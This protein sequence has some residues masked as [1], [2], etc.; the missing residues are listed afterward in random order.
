[1]VSLHP[2]MHGE[3]TF[4]KDAE[5]SPQPQPETFGQVVIDIL[6]APKAESLFSSF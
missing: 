4:L 6:S 3:G 2:G 1:M 5:P